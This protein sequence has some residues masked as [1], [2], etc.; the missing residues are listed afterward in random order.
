MPLL[1]FMGTHPILTV[2]LAVILGE[3]VVRMFELVI[4]L[5]R[6]VGR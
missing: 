4:K 1:N 6:E 2:I 3:V 5:I